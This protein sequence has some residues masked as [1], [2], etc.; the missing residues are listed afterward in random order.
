M[1]WTMHCWTGLRKNIHSLTYTDKVHKHYSHMQLC[2]F[3]VPFFFLFCILKPICIYKLN[4]ISLSYISLSLSYSEMVVTLGKRK[5]VCNWAI[6]PENGKQNAA[7][8]I[9]NNAGVHLERHP[10]VLTSRWSALK[11]FTASSHSVT[12]Q[13]FHRSDRQARMR[14]LQTVT[15]PTQSTWNKTDSHFRR[16]KRKVIRN[17]LLEIM[18]QQSYFLVALTHHVCPDDST[19]INTNMI[20]WPACTPD[21]IQNQTAVTADWWTAQAGMS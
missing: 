15:S 7:K 11:T 10:D 1:Q 3:T 13:S 14:S 21:L 19:V 20:H 16:Q 8:E 9:H 5:K 6:S 2:A 17:A 18:L 12:K 4:Y